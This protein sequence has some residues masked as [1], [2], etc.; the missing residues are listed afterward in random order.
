MPSVSLGATSRRTCSFFWI[1]W[2]FRVTQDNT[3]SNNVE[4]T[5]V[6]LPKSHPVSRSKIQ[7][8]QTAS[9][10]CSRETSF[11]QEI[12]QQEIVPK[13]YYCVIILVLCHGYPFMPTWL[14]RSV[15]SHP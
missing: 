9:H 15:K 12:T 1:V 10:N 4:R 13:T 8:D 2:L 6:V 3:L 7:V 11:T 5:V 14:S